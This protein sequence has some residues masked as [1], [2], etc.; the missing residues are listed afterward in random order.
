MA[1]F[2]QK[3]LQVYKTTSQ[4]STKVVT[5]GFAP[6]LS[7]PILEQYSESCMQLLTGGEQN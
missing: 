7:L 6:F 2:S 5:K 3:F 1:F 4:S